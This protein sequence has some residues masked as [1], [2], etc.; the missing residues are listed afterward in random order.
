MDVAVIARA[1]QGD[2]AA[3]SEIY[4]YYNAPIHRY[5]YRLLGNPEQADDVTQ[6]TFIRAYQR[7]P[8]LDEDPNLSAWLY[9]IASNACLDALRRRR[10]ITWLPM[11][12]RTERDQA[13]TTD[14]IAPQIVEGEAVSRV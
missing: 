13:F 2:E 6:E 14:D 1:R 8:V 12:E 10:R 5:V 3:F 4:E 9:R 7:L 11:L